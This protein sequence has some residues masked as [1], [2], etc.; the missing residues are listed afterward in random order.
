MYFRCQRRSGGHR[1]ARLKCTLQ[2]DIH[3]VGLRNWP[4]RNRKTHM[5]AHSHKNAGLECTGRSCRNVCSRSMESTHRIR[6]PH[7]RA[8]VYTPARWSRAVV[9]KCM[10]QINESMP[11]CAAPRPGTSPVQSPPPPASNSPALLAIPRHCTRHCKQFH[12]PEDTTLVH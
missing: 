2:L 1:R 10:L 7:G 6:V 11:A 9:P 4:D 12:W 8:G 3:D 5:T